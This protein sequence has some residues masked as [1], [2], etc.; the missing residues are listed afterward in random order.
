MSRTELAVA[1]FASGGGTNLQSLLDHAATDPPWRVRLVV[2]DREDAGALAR[3]AAAGARTRVIATRGREPADVA[4]ETL[5]ALRECQIDVVLLAGYLKLVPA[6]VVAAYPGR[7]LNIH[8]ALLPSF[9]GKGMYGMHVHRAVLASGARLSGPT[10]HL[11]D[12]VYD[13]GRILAQWPVPVLAD[14][15]PE[16]LQARV[17]AREHALYPRVMDHLAQAVLAGRPVTPLPVAAEAWSLP[18]SSPTRTQTP[19]DPA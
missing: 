18:A 17:L 1:V 13:R 9:G 7:M 19:E 12:E 11:V 4:A 10:V 3:G 8:P 16:A 6:D 14:D 5:A 15:T 2:S